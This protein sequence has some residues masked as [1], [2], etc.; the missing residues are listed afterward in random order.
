MRPCIVA[1]K[2]EK[3]KQTNRI[4]RNILDDQLGLT[5]ISSTSSTNNNPCISPT[6]TPNPTDQN[7]DNTMDLLSRAYRELQLDP[8]NTQ[9]MDAFEALSWKHLLQ[10]APHHW[11]QHTS[12][13]T[14]ALSWIATTGEGSFKHKTSIYDDTL[15]LIT[16]EFVRQYARTIWPE[17]EAKRAHLGFRVNL[18]LKAVRVQTRATARTIQCIERDR[19]VQSTEEMFVVESKIGRRVREYLMELLLTK[20][21]PLHNNDGVQQL[22]DTVLLGAVPAAGLA[23]V[24]AET[25]PA[26][27]PCRQQGCRLVFSSSE[28]LAYHLRLAHPVTTHA[29]PVIDL[30]EEVNRPYVHPL[31]PSGWI[32]DHSSRP[33]IDTTTPVRTEI[34]RARYPCPHEGCDRVYAWSQALITHQDR[35]HP[36]VP[37]VTASTSPYFQE[38]TSAPYPTGSDE[39]A[40]EQDITG[41]LCSHAGCQLRFPDWVS[42]EAHAQQPHSDDK[43]VSN[44]SD[45]YTAHIGNVTLSKY[46]KEADSF[47]QAVDTPLLQDGDN[48]TSDTKL[49]EVAVKVESGCGDTSCWRNMSGEKV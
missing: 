13:G 1:S 10:H 28:A 20:P 36:V 5:T 8:N 7:H 40:G 41:L 15:E 16:Y 34:T 25:M 17:L 38:N 6:T 4:F 18:T 14:L 48:E 30:T 39:T 29:A 24:H 26:Y 46:D 23:L 45:T 35:A 27:S 19:G 3:P 42:F 22:L 31:H 33:R 49:Q 11:L 32:T 2:H 21:V 43:F 47:L 44:S 9:Q 37:Q 12:D